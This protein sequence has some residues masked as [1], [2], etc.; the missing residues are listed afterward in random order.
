[1]V[2]NYDIHWN[3]VRLMQRIGRVDRRLN[4]DIEKALIKDDP[5]VSKT[6][7]KIFV[8]N[9]LPPEELN[10]LLSLY[11]RVQGRA[12]LISKTLGIPGGRLLNAEDLLDDVKVFKAFQEEYQGQISVDE[13]LRLD[14]LQL[15]KSHPELV[16]VIENMPNGA[17][18]AKSGPSVGLFEC[19]IEPVKTAATDDTESIWTTKDGRVRWTMLGSD[20]AISH[21][22]GQIAQVIRSDASTKRLSV[23]DQ[24]TVAA[25]IKKLR[26]KQ[27]EQVQKDSG[28]PM[29]APRPI[30]VCW[31]EIQ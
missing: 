22:F 23:S 18:S 19:S 17:H 25:S 3:P 21:D 30:P 29:D 5:S 14:Y 13:Q 9:F 27:I 12:V 28:L 8:R 20:G 7:G 24:V 26:E 6:R 31:M 4:L 1:M 10:D 11:S 16:D 2:V 15:L